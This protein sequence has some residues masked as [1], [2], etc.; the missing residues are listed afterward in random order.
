MNVENKVKILLH[1]LTNGHLD[2]L[3]YTYENCCP[4][5]S[6]SFYLHH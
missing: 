2:Y 5:K 6:R 4:W 3:K 1:L